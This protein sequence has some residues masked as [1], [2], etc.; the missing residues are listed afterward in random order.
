MYKWA[1]ILCVTAFFLLAYQ[2]KKSNTK[3]HWHWLIS[4]LIYSKL[5]V[6]I[7]INFSFNLKKSSMLF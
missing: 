7:A 2:Q 1:V 5:A 4:N 3:I 6:K